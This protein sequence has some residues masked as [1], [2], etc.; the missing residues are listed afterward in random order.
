M[1]TEDKNG[2]LHY[3]DKNSIEIHE[4]DTVRFPNGKLEKIYLTEDDQLG[5]DATNPAW[6]KNGRAC[7]CEYGIYPL[8]LIDTNE[9]EVVK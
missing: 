8:D 4:G 9:I 6:I 5:T 1:I 7:E 3:F 2:K